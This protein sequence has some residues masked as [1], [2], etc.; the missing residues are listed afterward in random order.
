MIRLAFLLILVAATGPLA[1]AWAQQR[2]D[3]DWDQVTVET[4]RGGTY[5]FDVELALTRDQQA[6]GLMF[7]EAM[8]QDQGMLFVFGEEAPRSFWMRNTL[9]PLDMIFIRADG[10]IA[11][12]IARAEPQ[13][14]T[15]RPSEGPVLGVLEI[16][17]GLAGLLG[18]G[19]GDRVMH[20]AFGPD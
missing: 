11:N 9:I 6:F 7:V 1:P 8:P 15:S 19:A 13:T 3:F 5:T 18:I 17:G 20:P 2:P 10:T 14:E 12:V 16:N 4:Q